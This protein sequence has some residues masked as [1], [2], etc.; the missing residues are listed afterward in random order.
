MKY[1][2]YYKAPGQL[3]WNKIKDVTADLIFEGPHK[4]KFNVRVI[5]TENETRYEIPMTWAIKF[6]TERF[7]SIKQQMDAEA[8][9]EIKIK[10]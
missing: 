8:G 1:N 9:Q 3:F 6:S 4:Q 7:Y 10:R 5:I 2:A